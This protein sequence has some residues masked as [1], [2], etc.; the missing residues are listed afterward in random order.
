M[1]TKDTQRDSD[2]HSR[3]LIKLITST[4]SLAI[5]TALSQC[6]KVSA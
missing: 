3:K 1:G 2:L 4:H 5:C 6:F